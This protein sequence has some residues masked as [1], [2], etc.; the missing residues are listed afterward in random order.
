MEDKRELIGGKLVLFRRNGL[1]QARVPLP[2]GHYLW[3]SLKTADEAVATQAGTRLFYQTE[4]KLSEGLPVHMRTVSSVIDELVAAREQDNKLGK[5]AKR[6]S[7]IKHTS[8]GMLRQIKR[9]VKFW[10]EFASSRPIQALDD[11]L[12]AAYV[13]WREIYYHEMEKLPKNA[14]LDPTDKTLQWEVMAGKMLVKFAHDR[15]YRG[16][17]PLPTYSFVPKR[18][19]ARPA[20]TLAEFERIVVALQGEVDAART[21]RQRAARELLRDYVITLARSGLRVGELNSL[22]IRDIQRIKDTDGR[23][24]VQLTVYGKTLERGAIPH[25]DLGTMLIT[26]L[27]RRRD[28]KPDDYLFSMEGGRKIITLADQFRAFLERHDLAQNGRGEAFSLYSL[29]HFYAMRAYARDTDVF[30]M[31]RNMGTSVQMIQQY[32]GK[33][34]VP[35]S[36][37]RKLGGEYGE[38]HRGAELTRPDLTPEQKA[39]R[40]ERERQRRAAAKVLAGGTI[41]RRK[42]ARPGGENQNS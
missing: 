38:Y 36:K 14:K 27:E 17:K 5:A 12:L 6:G 20:F 22:R 34:A 23:D 42:P 1:W 10:R 35:D 28:T 21:D 13:P 32:Y 31:S 19:R 37:A 40:A 26:M 33:G 16:N 39:K 9:V 15:G 25:I 30:T 29:R 7:N 4:T 8:D 3:R 41:K 18:K 11:K 24:N 2:D